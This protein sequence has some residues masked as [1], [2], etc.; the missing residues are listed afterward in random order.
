MRKRWRGY[1]CLRGRFIRGYGGGESDIRRRSLSPRDSITFASIV[2][3]CRSVP[4][5]VGSY[6]P[7]YTTTILTPH[8]GRP[9][10]R[11][12]QLRNAKASLSAVVDNAVRGEPAII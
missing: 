3:S 6:I 1:A 11:E 12:I 10:M 7:P 5:L 8:S 2:P 4:G 9:T